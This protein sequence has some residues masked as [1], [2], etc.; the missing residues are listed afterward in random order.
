MGSACGVRHPAPAARGSRLA[1]CF[2]ALALAAVLPARAAEEDLVAARNAVHDKLYAVAVTHAEAYLKSVEARPADGVE[3]LQLLQQALCEQRRYSE[4]LARLDAWAAVAGAAPDAGTFPFWRSLGLL[5]TGRPKECIQVAE[6]ALAQKIA[7][8]NADAL[9]RLVARARLSLDDTNAALSAYAEVDKRSTNTA[10]R[11]ANLLEWANALEAVGRVGDALGI[12]VRQMEL[13]VTGP[14]TDEGRLAYGRLLARQK[15]RAEAE[16]ALRILG[17][18]PSAAEFNRVQAWVE[19]SQLALDAGRTNDAITAARSAEELAVRPESRRLAAFQLADLLLAAPATLDEGVT[20]MKAYV[21]AFPEGASGAEAQFRLAA[22]LLRHGRHEAA[23]AE[24][25][26]FL[27]TFSGDRSREAAALEGL[28][29]ALFRLARYG[30]AANALQQAHDRATNDLVRASCLFQAG[31]AQLA[32]GQFRQA[33]GTYR[34]VAA[35]YPYATQAPRALFQAADS[36]E[37]AGDAEAAQAAF[38][39]AAQ[40]GGRTE[41]GI[42]AQ[43]RLAAL[44]AARALVDQALETYS[45]VLAATTNALARGEALMGRGRTHYR[46]YHFDAAALDFKAAAET[47]PARR[48]E[49]EFLRTMCL[50]GEGQDEQARKAAVDF[51][52]AF[53]NSPQL[54]D[55][56]LWLAKFDYN[57]NRLDEASRRLLQYADTWPR[58]SAADAAVLWAGR[59]AFRRADYTNTV[60]LMSR[61]QREYPQSARVAESRFVQGDALYMLARYDEAVLVFDEIINRYADSDW[62]T[63]A[64]ARKGDCLFFL[65]SNKP[66]RYDEALKAYRE[67]LGRRDATPETL[68]QAEFRIGR[69]LQKKRQV[70]AAIDQF[71]SRVVLRYLDDRSKGIYYTEAAKSW[72]VQAAFE[73]A[74]LLE[75]KKEF[76]QAERILNRVIQSDAPGRED[77]EQRIKRLRKGSPGR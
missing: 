28:G 58:A 70:D 24:Y 64:W 77:A 3:A 69:C 67:V 23:A 2:L 34:R 21:R 9:Q 49:A 18:N 72:F 32:A 37:R 41:L 51:I 66:A 15:R 71:Y 33:A 7:P 5:G 44:Q 73:A 29:T 11:A 12:L 20:R 4:A 22:A 57:R 26:V 13:N 6:G 63:P 31:D 35:D 16:N 50:Y 19:L 54:S 17:Q 42:Q 43:L 65:G 62:V 68:L 56:V 14:V 38:T 47:L 52:G 8:E 25:R 60:N 40:R 1:A 36:L 45:Q 74:D 46:A 76:D 59:V 53:T 55:M 10:T 48:D 75:Q 30:E 27:E 61:L 39:L